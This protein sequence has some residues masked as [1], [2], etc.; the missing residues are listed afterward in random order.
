MH[1]KFLLVLI[2][3]ISFSGFAQEKNPDTTQVDLGYRS[4]LFIKYPNPRRD[5]LRK[6]R[7]EAHWMGVE[8]GM[9]A[10]QDAGFDNSFSQAPF[11][12]N[13]PAKSIIVNV[14]PIEYKFNFGTPFVGLTS[15]LG[16]SFRHIAFNDNYLLKAPSIEN[17]NTLSA[18]IDTILSY[19]KN[20][21][22]TVY[23]TVPLLLEFVS[24]TNE[25]KSFYGS[26]GVIGS[27]RIGSSYLRKGTSNGVEFKYKEK[28]KFGLNPF[29][30]DATIRLGYRNLGLFVNYGII[31]LFEPNKSQRVHP[32]TFGISLNL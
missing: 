10:L 19:K 4:F 20:R 2:V 13:N 14:N 25:W 15:G 7:S 27:V 23:V 5:S 32:L 21:L 3:L 12:K 9:M 8:I 6:K 18:E 31:Q 1:N 28:N 17:N 29:Q 11:L 22:N 24:Q 26:I 16:F 30:L